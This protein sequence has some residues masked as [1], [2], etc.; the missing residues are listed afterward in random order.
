MFAVF[1][2]QIWKKNSKLS[3]DGC[4]NY[5]NDE[6]IATHPVNLFVRWDLIEGGY[7]NRGRRGGEKFHNFVN[8]FTRR[9]KKYVDTPVSVDL[10]T[11]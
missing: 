9:N 10:L 4:G 5:R 11:F 2:L 1:V 8:Q 6:D 7:G 3:D